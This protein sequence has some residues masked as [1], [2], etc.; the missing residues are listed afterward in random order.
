MHEGIAL[1]PGTRSKTRAVFLTCQA[2]TYVRDGELENAAQ[3][4][5]RSLDVASRIT[6][7]GA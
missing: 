2:E 3:T 6:H 4:A 1:L 5:T 7:P